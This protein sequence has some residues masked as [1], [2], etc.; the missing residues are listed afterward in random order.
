MPIQG[1]FGLALTADKAVGAGVNKLVRSFQYWSLSKR[2]KALTE[3][4][5]DV[6]DQFTDLKLA[7]SSSITAWQAVKLAQA[8]AG[9]SKVA[10]TMLSGE[11]YEIYGEGEGDVK[12]SRLVFVLDMLA[13]GNSWRRDLS[14]LL[15]EG[16]YRPAYLEF[17]IVSTTKLVILK[18]HT[19]TPEEYSVM[20]VG[21]IT[22]QRPSSPRMSTSTSMEISYLSG[23]IILCVAETQAG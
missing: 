4:L 11:M 13:G 21:I 3:L 16:V 17:N 18:H 7:G 12:E 10:F 1:E 2:Q 20:D 15:S 14:R 5:K 9:Y 8:G 23:K 6:D 22:F 19:F